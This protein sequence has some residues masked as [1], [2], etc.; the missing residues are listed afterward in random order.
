MYNSNFNSNNYHKSNNYGNSNQNQTSI[1]LDVKNEEVV[2]S[3]NPEWI[4]KGANKAFVTYAEAAGKQMANKGLTTSKIRNIF[5]EIKR[6]QVSGF[7]KE[8]SSFYL[9]SPKVAYAVGREKS[10]NRGSIDG[11]LLFQDIFKKATEQVT[12][13]KSYKNFCDFME[14]LVAYHKAFGGDK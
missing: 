7:E 8:K 13:T 9:L 10:T 1:D 5:G 6:I 4:T 14:A 11:I 2:L 12:D 3:F